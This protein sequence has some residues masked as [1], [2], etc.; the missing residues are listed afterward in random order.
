MSLFMDM[1]VTADAASVDTSTPAM[2]V[3]DM[4]RR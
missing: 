1:R 2:P 3:P 4:G